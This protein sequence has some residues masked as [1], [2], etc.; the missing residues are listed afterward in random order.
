MKTI[1]LVLTVLVFSSGCSIFKAA[2]APPPIALDE[3]TVGK[4]RNQIISI[5]GLPRSTETTPANERTDV[6]EFIDGHEAAS[7]L[8]ILLYIAGDVFTLGLAELVFWP[9]EIVA[10]QGNEGRAIVT[11]TPLNVAKD[12]L[13]TTRAGKAWGQRLA[14]QPVSQ[15]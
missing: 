15:E 14:S 13:V 9:L 2:N 10:M 5:L 7:K 12:V 6:H 4:D 11:Y 3:V 1:L 8:R